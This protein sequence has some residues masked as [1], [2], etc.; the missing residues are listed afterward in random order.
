[1]AP[2]ASIC[3]RCAEDSPRTLGLLPRRIHLPVQSSDAQTPWEA[4]LQPR[5]ITKMKEIIKELI[6]YRHLLF[7][8]AWKDIKI[9]YKQT[10][11]GYFW[12]LLM[13]ILVIASGLLVRK[14]FSM[15]SNNPLTFDSIASVSVKALPWAF[16]IGS[17]RFAT[18]SLTS[19]SNLITKIYF[20]RELFP[21]SAIFSNLFDFIIASLTLAVILTITQIGVS[22]N[23]A[24]LP[25]LILL[26]ITLTTAFGM[27]LA[28]ANLFFR[29]VK[30]IVE[31]L[32]MFG[33]FFTPVF[34]EAKMF[35]DWAFVILLNPIANIL[36]AF[37]NVVVLHRPPDLSWLVYTSF[38][39]IFGLL[40]SWKIFKKAEYAFAESI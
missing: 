40:I 7:M 2:V 5:G 11:M 27:L 29:D 1:M 8:L 32:L 4:I 25:V 13:P 6:Q 12:A 34:Y 24:W 39:A 28:C 3:V 15:L 10:I 38:F 26:M 19:N 35:G 17:I 37:N 21:L 18:T 31:V 33:I 20:P 22:I 36:E 14:A 9:K 23:L 30:Y 16:F